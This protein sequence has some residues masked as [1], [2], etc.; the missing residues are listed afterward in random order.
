[1]AKNIW[2]ITLFLVAVAVGACSSDSS[3]VPESESETASLMVGVEEQ[4]FLND[5]LVSTSE[6]PAEVMI[7]HDAQTDTRYVTLLAGSADLFRA[8]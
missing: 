1:M 6:P 2:F 7:L 3:S 8:E 4:V 5:R